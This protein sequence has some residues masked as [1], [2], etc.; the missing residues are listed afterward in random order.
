VR[1]PRRFNE[2]RR[3]ARNPADD[4]RKAREQRLAYAYDAYRSSSLPLR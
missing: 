4:A 1:F 2:E 3:Q